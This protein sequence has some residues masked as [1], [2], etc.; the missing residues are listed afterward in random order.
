MGQDSEHGAL[1]NSLY[2]RIEPFGLIIDA[3]AD[4]GADAAKRARAFSADQFRRHT[5]RP[6]VGALP[7]NNRDISYPSLRRLH[8]SCHEPVTGEHLQPQTHGHPALELS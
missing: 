7:G 2:C 1:L 5:P 6:D 8:G 4:R 3:D